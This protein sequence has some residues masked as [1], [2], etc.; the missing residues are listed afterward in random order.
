MAAV[1]L[2][3]FTIEVLKTNSTILMIALIQHFF[4]FIL[5]EMHDESI[6]IDSSQE[7]QNERR[8]IV[9]FE[10]SRNLLF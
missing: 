3:H 8:T 7:I 6:C 2:L 9:K 1:Q 10:K 5:F 4:F